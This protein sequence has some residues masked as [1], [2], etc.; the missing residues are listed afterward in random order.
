[1]MGGQTN[2]YKALSAIIVVVEFLSEGV[3]DGEHL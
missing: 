2:L 1:M 3:K